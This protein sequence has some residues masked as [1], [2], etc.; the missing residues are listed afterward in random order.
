MRLVERGIAGHSRPF[1]LMRKS[2]RIQLCKR[3]ATHFGSMG[4]GPL[5]ERV[6]ERANPSPGVI[7]CAF[8][9][10]N[11]NTGEFVRFREVELWRRKRHGT[12]SGFQ[13]G[14]GLRQG[15]VTAITVDRG[16]WVVRPF[17][18]RTA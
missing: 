12:P 8:P 13:T 16:P 10:S 2:A 15:V 7:T 9:E 3:F 18:D 14:P 1:R 6:A 5:E 4:S 11:R 17:G